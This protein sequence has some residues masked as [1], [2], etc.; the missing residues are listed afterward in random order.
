M[1]EP[2]SRYYLQVVRL[3]DS[4]R[5]FSQTRSLPGNGT[6]LL[7]RT[8][9]TCLLTMHRK[10]KNGNITVGHCASKNHSCRGYSE[11][12]GY[13]DSFSVRKR[14]LRGNFRAEVAGGTMTGTRVI[15]PQ[16]EYQSI[17]KPEP[18]S[19]SSSSVCW[20]RSEPVLTRESF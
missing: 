14:R 3:C 20:S 11:S 16:P 15:L 8:R 18:G 6:C 5:P 10:F 7:W 17:L 9:P 1:G 2:V 19:Y 12:C 13:V 4:R